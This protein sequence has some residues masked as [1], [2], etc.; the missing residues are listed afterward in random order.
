MSIC[1]EFVHHT[2][3]AHP[4]SPASLTLSRT[5]GLDSL[6]NATV[7]P[8]S[9]FSCIPVVAKGVAFEQKEPSMKLYLGS[10]NLRRLPGAIFN[11]EH[12]TLLSLRGNGLVEIPPAIGKLRNLEVLNVS[13]NSLR[14]LPFELLELL[15]TST[16]LKELLLHP[17]PFHRPE[18]PR[19]MSGDVSTGGEA[20]QTPFR[21]EFAARS[22]VQYSDTA[23]AVYSE[24]RLTSE[25]DIPVATDDPIPSTVPY[26]SKSA[27]SS[28]IQ[29]VSRV[30]TMLE[31]ALRACYQTPQLKELRG[32]LPA[33][34]PRHLHDYLKQ[35][36][37]QREAGGLT[38]SVCG[39]A[40]IV[41]RSQWIEWWR[42]GKR[43]V[44]GGND[45]PV[46]TVEPLSRDPEEQLVPFIR[47]G[48]SWRCV[49]PPIS[50]P[51]LETL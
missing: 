36:L 23:G 17:N 1:R 9:Q 51:D 18:S 27:V 7:E 2:F 24:F 31:L 22:P 33:D 45:P 12:L 21:G 49:P 26:L 28:S 16:R 13:Q 44:A 46:D 29:M 35:A 19:E 47:R 11:I 50:R 10:N 5:L 3:L 6:S 40:I 38:C 25:V 32:L 15:S 14:C 34:A 30:P 43:L 4:C 41:P 48:C 39:R 8:L 42:L 37:E 20:Q